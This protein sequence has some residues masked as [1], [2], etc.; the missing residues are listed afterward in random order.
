VSAG[1][2]GLGVASGAV[3]AHV[4]TLQPFL[5]PLSAG[6]LALAYDQ[7]YRSRL[8]SRRGWVW[9]GVTTPLTLL[10]WALPYLGR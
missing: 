6:F 8:G 10:F 1:F 9:L 7:A 5:V 4:A 2:G 3:A